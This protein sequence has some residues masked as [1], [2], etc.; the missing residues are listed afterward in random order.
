MRDNPGSSDRPDFTRKA[1]VTIIEQVKDLKLIYDETKPLAIN[2]AKMVAEKLTVMAPSL[3]AVS[4]GEIKLYVKFFD[5]L[6][7][8]PYESYKVAEIS[9]RGRAIGLT[10]QVLAVSEL[11]PICYRDIEIKYWWD[12]PEP[13]AWYPLRTNEESS[14]GIFPAYMSEKPAGIYFPPT[15]PD[16]LVNIFVVKT[17]GAAPA[18]DPL[19]GGTGTID[20]LPIHYIGFGWKFTTEFEESFSLKVGH[21]GTSTN[22]IRYRGALIYGLYP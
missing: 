1:D 7:L 12:E 5:S 19:Q 21:G 16:R 18:Y 8:S 22:S 11:E 20:T 17:T 3:Q 4:V 14:G 2:I 13:T 15:S 10:C 9:G 6:W